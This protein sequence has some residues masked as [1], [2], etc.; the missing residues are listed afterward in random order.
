MFGLIHSS[1]FR[2]DG[3]ISRTGS[4]GGGGGGGGGKELMFT[5][6]RT[7][8]ESLGSGLNGY[9]RPYN[10]RSG[11]DPIHSQNDISSFGSAPEWS[12]VNSRLIQSNFR[13]G[14]FWNRS[15]VTKP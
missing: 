8:T 2:R 1:R 4:A 3:F 15:R 5:R 13:T 10:N 11:T 9:T 6:D 14:S 7:D 12:C